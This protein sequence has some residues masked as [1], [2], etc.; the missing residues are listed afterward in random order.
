MS[1]RVN[2]TGHELRF[3]A[4]FGEVTLLAQIS[5]CF[6]AVVEIQR[7]PLRQIVLVVGY[8]VEESLDE[9]IFRAPRCLHVRFR[10]HLLQH[11]GGEL[12]QRLVGRRLGGLLRLRVPLTGGGWRWGRHVDGCGTIQIARTETIKN[13]VQ[14]QSSQFRE[15]GIRDI[16]CLLNQHRAEPPTMARVPQL[17]RVFYL[18]C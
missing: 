12:F 11:R 8:G 14:V 9:R 13:G 4:H 1:G 3:A 17:C 6:G 16:D 5:Q 7:V 18:A 2:E 10:A 15:S